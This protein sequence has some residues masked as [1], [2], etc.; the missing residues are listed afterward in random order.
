VEARRRAVAALGVG[1]RRL[2][3]AERGQDG[4]VLSAAPL[5]DALADADLAYLAVEASDGPMVT[6]L[7]FVVHD[8][9]VWMVIPRSSAKVSAIGRNAVVGLAVGDAE[10][11]AVLQ[12]QAHL[13]DPLRPT[14]MLTALPE[15]LRAPLAL[16]RYVTG[17]LDHLAGIIG[18]AGAGVLAPRTV[19]AL[20]PQRAIAVQP[21]GADVWTTGGWP[22]GA[23][24]YA[25]PADGHRAP[26]STG[27]VPPELRHLVEAAGP[28]VVGW[29][30]TAGPVALPATWDPA[31][32][33]ARI[34]G[35]LF[36]A[37]GC[38]PQARACVLFDGTEGT[39][40]DAKSGLVLRGR[41]SAARADG[42]GGNGG[43]GAAVVLRT[44]RVSWWHGTESHSIK[45]G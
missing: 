17:N 25:S 10:R 12:G 31:T 37:A 3:E 9:R 8:E 28:V 5:A 38:L 13:V 2:I 18:G 39:D 29:T 27:A 6:P 33:T 20:R 11:A 26:T 14:A 16:G 35:D 42:D 41:G 30:T 24:P 44:D 23:P 15:T 32:G 21:G 19:A 1:E 43:G 7:L 22:V 34:G 45:A 40:L 36:T 4:L